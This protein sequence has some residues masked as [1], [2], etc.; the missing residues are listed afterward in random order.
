MAPCVCNMCLSRSLPA[1]HK[2][3]N[4]LYYIVAST[5]VEALHA[6]LLSSIVRSKQVL[7]IPSMSKDF[8][9]AIKGLKG[10]HAAQLTASACLAQ[11][12]I[13]E[14]AV[15]TNKRQVLIPHA[16]CHVSLSNQFATA[17]QQGVFDTVFDSIRTSIKVN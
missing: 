16:L 15:S 4:S 1:G 11:L 13:T 12:C 17:I 6:I 5:A 9:T 7:C 14:M 8:D 3:S 2:A 10:H